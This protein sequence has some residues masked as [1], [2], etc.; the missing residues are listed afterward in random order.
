MYFL[1][2][3]MASLGFRHSEKINYTYISFSDF[4][5]KEIIRITLKLV[6]SD[7]YRRRPWV[8]EDAE[9]MGTKKKKIGDICNIV[10][11]K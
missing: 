2:Y 5:S 3:N 7:N 6:C 1:R 10:N 9:W 8:R 4:F 11:K